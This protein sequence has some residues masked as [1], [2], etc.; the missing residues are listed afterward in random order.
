MS[1]GFPETLQI[2]NHRL[3][4]PVYLPDATFGVVRSVDAGD[5]QSCQ[6]QAIVMNTFHLMQRPGSSVIQALGGL[7]RMS[8][9]EG[10]IVTDSGGFQAYSLIHQNPKFGAVSDEGLVFQPEGATRKYQLTPEKCIQLQL[11]YGSDIVICL[12]VVRM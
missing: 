7:H 2:R 9:W 4:L 11:S 10:P 12:D 3:E 1:A 8:G 5:L 6:V